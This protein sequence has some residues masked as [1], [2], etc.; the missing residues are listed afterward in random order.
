[1][2]T[3]YLLSL[4]IMTFVLPLRNAGKGSLEQA[5]RQTLRQYLIFLVLWGLGIRWVYWK[6]PQ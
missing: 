4:V 6:L 3:Y 5:A 1:M 2:Q